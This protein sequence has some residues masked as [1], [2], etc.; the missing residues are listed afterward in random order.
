MFCVFRRVPLITPYNWC[1][2]LG[3]QVH[4]KALESE[5]I[6]ITFIYYS[7]AIFFFFSFSS[8]SHMYTHSW[9]LYFHSILRELPP[10]SLGSPP[11]FTFLGSQNER[12]SVGIHCC[13]LLTYTVYT[14]FGSSL[15][16]FFLAQTRPQWA[17]S[18]Y[19]M[20]GLAKKWFNFLLV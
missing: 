4:L 11:H 9:N 5:C 10:C 6:L 19:I 15:S 18:F 17:W 13:C 16:G 14:N 2:P 3:N 8:C 12:C 1:L 7:P 20:L